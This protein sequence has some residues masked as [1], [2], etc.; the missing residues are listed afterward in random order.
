MIIY[1]ILAYDQCIRVAQIYLLQLFYGKDFKKLFK[2]FQFQ[3]EVKKE[4][5]LRGRCIRLDLF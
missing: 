2:S 5:C 4:F 1:A 3:I